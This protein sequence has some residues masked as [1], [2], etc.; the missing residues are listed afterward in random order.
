M[1]VVVLQCQRILRRRQVI[2][3][4]YGLVGY[5]ISRLGD[6]NIF[7]E[8]QGW[9]EIGISPRGINIGRSAV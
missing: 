3:I 7:W 2:E 8:V 1:L 4:G 9:R 5:E 6:E